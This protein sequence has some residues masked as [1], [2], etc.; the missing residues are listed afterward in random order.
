M[1]NAPT[2]R[3]SMTVAALLAGALSTTCVSAA[4]AASPHRDDL[5]KH[6]VAA[7]KALGATGA[8]ARLTTS[9]GRDLTATGGVADLKTKRP[10]SPNGYFRIA[11]VT[12]AFTATV[13]MQLAAEGRLSVDDKVERWLPG[14]VSKNGNDGRKISI[15]NLLQHTGGVHDDYPEFTSADDF[16]KH[17]N[18]V[19]TARQIV[20]RAMRHKP[21]FQPPAKKWM[22]SNTGYVLLGM[23]I[24]RATGHTWQT[25]I[26]DRITRPLGLKH[27][28]ANGTNPKLPSPHAKSY[29]RFAPGGPLIDVTEQV[30]LVSNGEAGLVSTTADLNR[31]FRA[32][33]AGR[34]LPPKQMKQMRTTVPVG[35]KFQ[36]LMP[37]AR[38][39]LGIFSRPL[40]CGGRYWGHEGGDSGWISTVAVTADGRRSVALSLTGVNANSEADVLRIVKAEDKLVDDALCKTH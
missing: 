31:F 5:L 4:N 15:R 34:L 14:V 1:T 8:Q 26:R 17:R 10:V 27:T 36:P 29:Q 7:F 9:H 12:K 30:G 16:Y 37:H 18:D 35:A 32:L 38:D 24:Q 2:L 23:I 39:G 40:T 3:R 28:F 6:D 11:S 20:D 13:I 33:A 22:Y 21:D 19:Y 25:E